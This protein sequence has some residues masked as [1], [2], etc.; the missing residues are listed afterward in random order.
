[1]KT[2]VVGAT[3]NPERYAYLATQMLQQYKHEVVLLGIKKGSVLG[4]DILNLYDKPALPD[5]HTITLYI[6]P[7]HQEAWIDYLL[8]LRPKRIIFN[9]GTENDYFAQRAGEAG[10][11]VVEGCTLVMLRTGQYA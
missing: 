1:M 11:D 10:I 9:P 3:P 7:Q 4:I 2:V 8:Q 6:G 5:V